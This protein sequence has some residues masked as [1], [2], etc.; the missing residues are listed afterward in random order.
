MKEQLRILLPLDLHLM[1]ET[2]AT[3]QEIFLIFGTLPIVNSYS[4]L[5]YRAHNNWQGGYQCEPAPWQVQPH[6]WKR[7]CAYRALS[8]SIKKEIEIETESALT[9]P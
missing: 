3:N 6:P 8:S 1:N 5:S 9:V 4:F 7:G 2:K